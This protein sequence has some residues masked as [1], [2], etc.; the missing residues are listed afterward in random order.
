MRKVLGT[1]LAL[2][3]I[4]AAGCNTRKDYPEPKIG[5]HDHSYS[6]IFGRLVRIPGATPEDPP[7]WVIRFGVPGDEYRG[8][9]ALTPAE[10]MRGYSG[11]EMV[12]LKGRLLEQNTTDA[13]SGR[14]YAVDS[15]Q[16][17]SSYR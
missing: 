8:E 10:R 4:V 3:A 12:E 11:G 6:R 7:T 2:L 9:L 5:W 1:F 17:W 16:M 13:F 15:I 14:W